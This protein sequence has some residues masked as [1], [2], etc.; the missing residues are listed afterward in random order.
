MR[1]ASRF[2]LLR[3]DEVATLRAVLARQKSDPIEHCKRDILN[4]GAADE[5][6]LKDLEKE[7]RAIVADAADFAESAAEPDARELFTD[8]LVG[9]YG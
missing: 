2:D 7:V 3:R 4:A 8:V 9:T 6:A 5:A 1:R